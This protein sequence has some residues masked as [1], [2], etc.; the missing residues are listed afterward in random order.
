MMNLNEELWNYFLTAFSDLLNTSGDEIAL[1]LKEIYDSEESYEINNYVNKWSE[2]RVSCTKFFTTEK[3]HVFTVQSW[4]KTLKNCERNFNTGNICG[5]ADKQD[6]NMC[7]VFIT[8]II[9]DINCFLEALISPTTQL[10]L[11]KMA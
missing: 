11:G 2:A 9:Y 1:Q 3:E 4:H 6:L 8:S 7:A 10:Y 5:K